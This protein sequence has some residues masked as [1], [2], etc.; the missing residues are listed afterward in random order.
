MRRKGG[1]IKNAGKL[2]N[3]NHLKCCGYE[4]LWEKI[5]LE[6]GLGYGRIMENKPHRRKENLSPLPVLTIH[7]IKIKH[8]TAYASVYA[9]DTFFL[10]RHRSIVGWRCLVFN[11]LQIVVA[12]LYCE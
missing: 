4:M 8:V 5:T 12:L 9:L 3:K 7:H 2:F 1:G 6:S 10:V 11:T